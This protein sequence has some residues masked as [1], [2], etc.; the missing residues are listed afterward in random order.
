MTRVTFAELGGC[1]QVA[2]ALSGLVVHVPE[3]QG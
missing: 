1:R 3:G 2:A